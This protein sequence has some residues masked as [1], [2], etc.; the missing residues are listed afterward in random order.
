M[1]RRK[2]KTDEAV[3]EYKL[4][5]KLDPQGK[6]AKEARKSLAELASAVPKK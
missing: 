3:A 6:H 4:S 5:L 1:A 2:G